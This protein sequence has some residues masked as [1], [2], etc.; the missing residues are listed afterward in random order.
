MAAISVDRSLPRPQ[1]YSSDGTDAVGFVQF[2]GNSPALDLVGRDVQARAFGPAAVGT[3]P[4]GYKSEETIHEKNNELNEGVF[5]DSGEKADEDDPQPAPL[6]EG[7]E[8]VNVL[9]LAGA[10]LRHVVKTL[11]RRRKQE[12]HRLRF[13]IHE[14]DHEVLARHLLFLQII[15]N[16]ALPIRERMELFL[17]LYGNT[18]VRERDS[19]YLSEIAP[20]FVELITDNSSHPLSEVIDLT[21]LKFKDRDVLQD[22]FRG[23]FKD[24][25][26]DIEALREQRLRGYYRERYDYRKNLMDSDY[27]NFIKDSAGIINWFHYKEFGHTGVAFETRLAGYSMPNKTLASYTEAV[28][29]S[30]GTTVQARGFWGDIINSPYHAFSTRTDPEAR[31]RLFKISSQQYR[32]T[33]TGIAEYN[34]TAYLSE[35]ETGEKFSLPAEVPEE[36]VYP[37]ASPLDTLRAVDKVVEVTE[38]ASKDVTH[39][40]QQGRRAP[41]KVDWPSLT[42][43][44]EGVQVILLT[45]DAKEVLKKP[46]YK[47]L[48]HRAFI[49]SMGTVPLFEEL[50]LNSS[51]ENPFNAPEAASSRIRKPPSKEMPDAF[52]L[53]RD[54]S[55][56]ASCMVRGAEVAVET[57]KYQAHFDGSIR[58]SFR[59]RVAQAAHLIGWKAQDEK[60]AVPRLESDMQER[61]YCELE[62]QASDFLRF[63][64]GPGAT[65][66]SEQRSTLADLDG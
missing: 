41:K 56:F 12:H 21:H 52:G 20:E 59:H 6:P 35:M 32:H 62:R 66:P 13:Y 39:A 51:N 22:V 37:Y 57:L 40:Q 3:N 17:S 9:I 45:G 55:A 30:K 4:G 49:G 18:L 24:V 54:E 43:A 48:F 28:D 38:A 26:F 50:G 31:S 53:K 2:W 25:A 47:G 19:T 29:R 63:V 61:G 8:P 44:M 64:T 10:D 27:Q 16:K 34:L 7:D 58:V 65:G 42:L 36:H 14:K 15:N 46:K 23:W 1:A 33:E 5:E 60:R 11:A